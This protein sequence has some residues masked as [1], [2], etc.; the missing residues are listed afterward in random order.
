MENI[1]DILKSCDVQTFRSGGKGGQHQ[2]KTESGVRLVHR[3][4][5]ITVIC[6]D[7]R[8]QHLNKQR[9]LDTLRKRLVK[10]YEKPT[11]RIATRVP[12]NRKVERREKKRLQGRKKQFRKR[13]EIE[14]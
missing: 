3:P 1:E 5:G 11:P 2:N 13:P 4:S 14:E 7:E 6:R 10:L 12:K 9:C 8:S